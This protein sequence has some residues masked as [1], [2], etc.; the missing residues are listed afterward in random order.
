MSDWVKVVAADELSAG[1]MK[2]VEVDEEDVVVANV[3]GEVLA[4]SDICSHQYVNLSDGWID[5]ETVECPQHG[6]KFSLRTG[7]VL[8]PPAT[9]PVAT[10]DV[11]IED[12]HIYLK[13]PKEPELT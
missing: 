6:S 8:N 3:G 4:L 1:S 11:K 13:G 2:K 9:Q 5:S 10:Y 7:E 12:G